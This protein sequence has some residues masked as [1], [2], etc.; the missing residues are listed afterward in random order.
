MLKA[1]IFFK[2]KCYFGR[3]SGRWSGLSQSG[4]IGRKTFA[5]VSNMCPTK[6]VWRLWIAKSEKR[7]RDNLCSFSTVC[8]QCL[9]NLCSLRT[10]CV[11]CAEIYPLPS[12]FRP[13]ANIPSQDPTQ[14]KEIKRL[15]ETL[16]EICGPMNFTPFW[17]EAYVC[18]L[19][20]GGFD[21]L[22]ISWPIKP[23]STA[24]HSFDPCDSQ[25]S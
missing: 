7:E 24:A 20:L 17:N 3:D 15:T 23:S 5:Q 11:Q 1:W 9:C 10:V 18:Y 2:V 12:Q 22:G 8:V 21:L 16:N 4:W 25:L 14:R 19:K 13:G 6:F